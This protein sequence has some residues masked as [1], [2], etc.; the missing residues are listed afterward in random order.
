MRFAGGSAA[1]GAAVYVVADGAG[2]GNR[3]LPASLISTTKLTHQDEDG[4]NVEVEVEVEVAFNKPILTAAN[5]NAFFTFDTGNVNGSNATKQ[6][7]RSINLSGEAAA[8]GTPT[9]PRYLAR[10]ESPVSKT[11]PPCSRRSPA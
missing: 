7:P 1:S 4:D 10:T 11:S 5:V 9:T 6:L 3:T 8:A 2:S